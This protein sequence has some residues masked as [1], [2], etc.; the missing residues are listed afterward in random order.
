MLSQR[1]FKDADEVFASAERIWRDLESSDWLEAFRADARI[2]SADTPA[3]RAV[4]RA[5]AWAAREQAGMDAAADA[6]LKVAAE[7]QLEITRLRLETL[8]AL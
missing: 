2:G 1:P 3:A 8:L 7:E 4:Q 6:N 5:P